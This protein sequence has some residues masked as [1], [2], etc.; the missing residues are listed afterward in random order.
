MLIEKEALTDLAYGWCTDSGR[1]E[2]SGRP[3]VGSFASGIR[4]LLSIVLSFSFFLK[5]KKQKFKPVR[6]GVA[7]DRILGKRTG[8]GNSSSLEVLI[9]DSLLPAMAG[10]RRR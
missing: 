5:K 10:T 9:A 3:A 4:T 6:M 7:A 1:K 8:A 2:F